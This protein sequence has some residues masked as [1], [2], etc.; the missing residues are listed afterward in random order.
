MKQTIINYLK[1]F[2]LIYA[3]EVGLFCTY[4]LALVALGLP[5]KYASLVG[6]VL[7]ILSVRGY[8]NWMRRG[9]DDA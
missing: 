8:M 2:I 6:L 5:V 9:N 4:G 7:S 3:M 1:F